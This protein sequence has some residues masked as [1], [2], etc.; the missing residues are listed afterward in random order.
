MNTKITL[1]YVDADNY[2][3]QIDYVLKGEITDKQLNEIVEY[4]EDGECIIAEQIGLP[5]PA[6]LFAENYDFPT[7]DDH[8]FTTIQEF[9]SGVPEASSLL[10]EEPPTDPN[11]T[12][13]VF[14]NKIIEADGWDVTNEVNRLGM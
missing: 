12:V 3:Q 9:Q 7:E 1:K 8:V 10:T 14:C 4:L 5:T 2:K 13:D 11:Y 6:L